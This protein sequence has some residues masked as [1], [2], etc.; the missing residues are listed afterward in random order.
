MVRWIIRSI[1]HAGP[2]ELF[3]TAMEH[4]L[5]QEIAQWVHHEGIDLMT[6]MLVFP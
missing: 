5:E 1:L 6:I 2:I 4:W 3:L